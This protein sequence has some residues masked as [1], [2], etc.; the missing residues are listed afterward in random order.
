VVAAL[1]MIKLKDPEDPK[2]L[3]AEQGLENLENCMP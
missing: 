2:R 3:M 1:A